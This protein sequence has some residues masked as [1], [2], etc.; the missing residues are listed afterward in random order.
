MALKTGFLNLNSSTNDSPKII[1]NDNNDGDDK[2]TNNIILK[3]PFWKDVISSFRNKI[4]RI[5]NNMNEKPND[6][7]FTKLSQNKQSIIHV[8]EREDNCTSKLGSLNATKIFQN[9]LSVQKDNTAE[10]KLRL[11]P[12]PNYDN[13]KNKPTGIIHKSSNLVA[14]DFNLINN[15]TDSHGHSSSRKSVKSNHNKVVQFSKPASKYKAST[16]SEGMHNS[17]DRPQLKQ[18]NATHLATKEKKSS[19]KMRGPPVKNHFNYQQGN[20]LSS[21]PM[22]GP[23]VS[24]LSSLD[25]SRMRQKSKYEKRNALQVSKVKFPSEGKK[26]RRRKKLKNRAKND[27]THYRRR[28]SR[29]RTQ[30]SAV[31]PESL[32]HNIETKSLPPVKTLKRY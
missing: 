21:L 3:K 23:P 16:D 9:N 5:R 6:S 20:T 32:V 28:S 13:K 10:V 30:G 11:T 26:K 19:L 15:D 22:I 31:F 18:S 14:D 17:K 1:Q 2:K 12:Q 27:G 4:F 25:D 24:T 29:T 8:D 7:E